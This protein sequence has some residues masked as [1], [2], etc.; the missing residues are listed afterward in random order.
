MTM[1]IVIALLV[2]ITSILTAVSLLWLLLNLM[3]MASA[4]QWDDET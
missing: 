3:E 1:A 4:S 2:A